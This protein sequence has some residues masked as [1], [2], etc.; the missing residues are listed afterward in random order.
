[1]AQRIF[2]KDL[3]SS[4]YVYYTSLILLVKKIEMNLNN[5][6][7]TVAQASEKNITL[8]HSNLTVYSKWDI[9]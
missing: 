8:K 6:V 9:I 3:H 5:N 4:L 2:T 1:M 7:T